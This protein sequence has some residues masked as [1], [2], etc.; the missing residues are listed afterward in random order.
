ML[1]RNAGP[2]LYRLTPAE[3]ALID[4]EEAAAAADDATAERLRVILRDAGRAIGDLE[5]H[6]HW[7]VRGWDQPSTLATLR[8]LAGDT[9]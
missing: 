5:F 6:G 1:F 7:P 3:Q 9:L 2:D 8:D 4:A